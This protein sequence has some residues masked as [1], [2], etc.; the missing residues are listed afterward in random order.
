MLAPK[1]SVGRSAPPAASPMVGIAAVSVHG[2]AAPAVVTEARAT[3][4][5]ARP[6]MR[7][8][9]PPLV[10]AITTPGPAG[11]VTSTVPDVSQ[12]PC[13]AHPAAPSPWKATESVI[14]VERTRKPRVWTFALAGWDVP[15]S[16]APAAGASVTRQRTAA[17]RA[18]V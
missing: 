9:T 5:L 11:T 1:T 7:S 14:A 16:K 15:V 8:L 18:K 2:A 12:T 13:A 4:D 10:K 3:P 6:P 17:P